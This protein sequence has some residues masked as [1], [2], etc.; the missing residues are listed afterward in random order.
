MSHQGQT[1][2]YISRTPLISFP[3][4]KSTEQCRR[5]MLKVPWARSQRRTKLAMACRTSKR[6][7][8]SE[9]KTCI[10]ILYHSNHTTKYFLYFFIALPAEF[11]F[12]TGNSFPL[13]LNITTDRMGMCQNTFRHFCR[14]GV[15]PRQNTSYSQTSDGEMKC[16][17]KK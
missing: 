11:C 6:E 12:S 5:R 13:R 3:G 14:Q 2:D 17:E 9:P 8:F 15:V 10:R 7:I 1:G 4:D 16:N